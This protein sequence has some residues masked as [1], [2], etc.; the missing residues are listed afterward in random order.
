MGIGTGEQDDSCK[1][2][3]GG[4]WTLLSECNDSVVVVR[5]SAYSA[6]HRSSCSWHYVAIRASV[7]QYAPRSSRSKSLASSDLGSKLV[8][9][10]GAEVQL[11]PRLQLHL[12]P[13]SIAPIFKPAAAAASSKLADHRCSSRQSAP[14]CT[15]CQHPVWLHELLAFVCVSLPFGSRLPSEQAGSVMGL[16]CQRVIGRVVGSRQAEAF[17]IKLGVEDFKL[18]C[19]DLHGWRCRARLTVRGSARNPIIGLFKQ[20]THDAIN[21]PG[22]RLSATSFT[23]AYVSDI[24]RRPNAQRMSAGSLFQVLGSVLSCPALVNGFGVF[25]CPDAQRVSSSLSF[26]DTTMYTQ[27]SLSAC[28]QD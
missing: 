5:C 10:R 28:Q 9:S 11:E 1:A 18:H 13:S 25:H 17:A 21:I 19:G 6:Q 16:L 4:E 2:V 24:C 22:T 7:P 26:I 20:G 23:L 8:L 3:K 14:H 15:Q 27:N 12:A